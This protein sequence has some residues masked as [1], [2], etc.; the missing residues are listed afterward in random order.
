MGLTAHSTAYSP[1]RRAPDAILSLH[2]GITLLRRCVENLVMA[3]DTFYCG[4]AKKRLILTK[5]SLYL[6]D[7]TIPK[8]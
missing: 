2:Y 8:F 5:A 3:D 7:A 6:S 4:P 1:G